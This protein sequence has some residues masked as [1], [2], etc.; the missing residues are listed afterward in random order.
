MARSRMKWEIIQSHY[1][2]IDNTQSLNKSGSLAFLFILLP[3]EEQ[4]RND[5]ACVLTESKK[6]QT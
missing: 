5:D 4:E 3:G 6:F 1:N 2:F